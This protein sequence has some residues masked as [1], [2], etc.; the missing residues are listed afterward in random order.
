M[1]NRYGP[2]VDANIVT[3]VNESETIVDTEW[4]FLKDTQFT[5]AHEKDLEISHRIQDEDVALCE[6]V[7]EGMHS[8]AVKSGRYVPAVETGIYRFHEIYLSEMGMMP[9]GPETESL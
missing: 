5:G 7:Q 3:P 9:P 6:R 2:F 1:V 8:T 4:Y